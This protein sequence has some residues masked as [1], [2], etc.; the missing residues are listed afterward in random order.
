VHERVALAAERQDHARMLPLHVP[1]CRPRGQELRPYGRDDWA[2]VL[3]DR[4]VHHRG[5]LHVAVGDDV[6]R[7]VD[8]AAVAD[9]GVGVRVDRALVE[10]VQ[11]RGF[12]AAAVLAD[13]LRDLV[14]GGPGPPGEEDPRP[15]AGERPGDSAADRATSAVDDRVPAVEQH[16]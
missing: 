8:A 10:R 6:H 15:L 11:Y 3:L 12:G 4:H 9:D 5:A 2:Q 7:D 13:V 1:G 14:Q 16:G